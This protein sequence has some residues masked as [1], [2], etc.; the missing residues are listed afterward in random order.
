MASSFGTTGEKPCGR[1][2]RPPT[3][4]RPCGAHH[5]AKIWKRNLS[6]SGRKISMYFILICLPAKWGY[7]H[8][9]LRP[10]F[11]RIHALCVC[12]H[13][14]CGSKNFHEASCY[15]CK[16]LSSRHLLACRS[17]LW[18]KLLKVWDY[19]YNIVFFSVTQTKQACKKYGCC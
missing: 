9:I 16:S 2:D 12:S 3:L 13:R 19:S 8:F 11:F 4:P 15:G 7:Y 10:R 5:R 17:V 6:N 14:Y 1:H 18:V